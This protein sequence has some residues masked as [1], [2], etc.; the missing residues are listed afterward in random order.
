MAR[1]NILGGDQEKA[2]PPRTG[3]GVKAGRAHTVDCLSRPPREIR[4]VPLGGRE[5]QMASLEAT[6]RLSPAY[7]KP[8]S[9]RSSFI[10]LLLALCAAREVK[11][12]AF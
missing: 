10:Y 3:S 6:R 11:W 5:R 2:S 1:K 12:A 9:V 8:P 4:M 7:T